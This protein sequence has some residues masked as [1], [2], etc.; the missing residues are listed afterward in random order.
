LRRRA[1]PGRYG[2][3]DPAMGGGRESTAF[4]NGTG[5]ARL[6][7]QLQGRGMRAL[8]AWERLGVR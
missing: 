5:A 3:R 7:R 1:A 8:Q 6:G 2:R 4:R